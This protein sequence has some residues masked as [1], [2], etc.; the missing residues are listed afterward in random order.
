LT[1]SLALLLVAVLVPISLHQLIGSEGPA[2]PVSPSEAWVPTRLDVGAE[3]AVSTRLQSVALSPNGT[4]MAVAAPDGRRPARLWSTVDGGR[5]WQPDTLDAPAGAAVA[6]AHGVSL[7]GGSDGSIRR[8]RDGQAAELVRAPDSCGSVAERDPRVAGLAPCVTAFAWANDHRIIAIGP[9]SIL[10]SEDAGV[11]W[12]TVR[13][14]QQTLFG[15]SFVTDSLGLIVGGAG[16][17][18]RTVDGGRSWAAQISGSRSLLEDV[19]FADAMVAVAVGSFGTILRSA[20]GGVSWSTV[21][22]ETRQHLRGVAFANP[23]EGV[24]VG[25]Y[26]TVLRTSDGGRSWRPQNAATRAHL[27]DVAVASDGAPVAVGWFDTVLRGPSLASSSVT[28]GGAP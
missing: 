8:R 18:L 5:S 23:T 4:G 19:A 25:L 22:S 2:R 28:T 27:L 7:V 11:A 1:S 17:I 14:P 15:V 24:A 3:E 10:V 16:T 26:G 6:L 9:A 21:S 13:A 20:D 12:E